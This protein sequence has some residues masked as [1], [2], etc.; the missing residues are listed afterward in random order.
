LRTQGILGMYMF[1]AVVFD[2]DGTLADTKKAVVVSFRKVLADVGCVVDDE[3][4][5]RRIGTGSRKTLEDALEHCGIVLDNETLEKLV[6]RKVGLQAELS[7]IVNLFEG[8]T[9]LLNALHG[10]TK[11]ALATMS[12]RKVIYRLLSE[13]RIEKYFDVVITADEILKP[14]PDPGIFLLSAT[15]LNVLPRDCVIIEDSVFGVKAAREAGM[16]CIA[17][18]SGAYTKDELR[19]QNPDL[20][21]DSI[22]EKEKILDFIFE[23]HLYTTR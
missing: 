9:A 21:V 13:K 17:I 16:K 6:R 3:F 19:N 11:I 10:R 18:P 7:T 22:T 14:K 12:S 20:L 1:K 4:I 15:E 2:W 5:E 23:E 8:A